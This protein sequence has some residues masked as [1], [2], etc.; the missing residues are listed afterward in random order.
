MA[1]MNRPM[2]EHF[3]AR[4]LAV[5]GPGAMTTLEEGVM[6]VLPLDMMA[7]PAYWDIQEIR[8]FSCSYTQAAGGA[9]NYSAIGL[10]LEDT[11][12]EILVRIIRWDAA[13]QAGAVKKLEMRRCPRTSFSSG[14]GRY[15]VG[16]DTRIP[17]AQDSHAVSVNSGSTTFPGSIIG[18]IYTDRETLLTSDHMPLIIS[19]GECM[20]AA[21]Q[22]ANQAT[23]QTIWWAEIPAYKAEL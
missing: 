1:Q 15:G 9:G 10:A 4:H 20:Y 6:G 11:T 8:I 7:D 17:E 21:E 14:P 18:N 2:Y 22:T 12:D 19:P 3:G 23:E 13:E 5:K 16:L